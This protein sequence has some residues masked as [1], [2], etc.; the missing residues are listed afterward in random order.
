M[1]DRDPKA[2]LLARIRKCLALGK[3]SNEH[4]AAA[5]IAKARALMDEHGISDQD[6][7][8]SEVGGESVKGNC[9]QRAPLWESCLCETVCHAIGVTVVIGYEGER[10]YIGVGAAPQ[11]AAYAFAV[12]FRKLKAER[13]HYVSTAL[14]RCK[15]ARK[16]QRADVFCQAWANACYRKVRALM[17]KAPL[18]DRVGQ[19]IEQR[20]GGSLITVSARSASTKGRDTSQDYWRGREKGNA[21]ELHGAVS[22]NAGRTELLA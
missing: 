17:P 13:A 7:A 11:I 16:R 10:N 18:D 3:S 12:L 8:L 20:Y 2:D 1:T 14:K 15:L 22:G 9:A 19:Y 6:I 5:A 4:E 21:V